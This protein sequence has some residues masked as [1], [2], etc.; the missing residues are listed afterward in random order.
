MMNQSILRHSKLVAMTCLIATL[1]G[2]AAA[3]TAVKKRNLEVETKMSD[4]IFLDPVAPEQQV[5]FVQLRNTS[6]KQDLKIK[7][8]IEQKLE[9]RGYTVT[10]NPKEAHYLLQANI[11]KAGKTDLRESQGLLASGYGGAISGAALGA[12]ASASM[13]SDASNMAGFGLLGA[14]VGFAADA[15]VEDVMFTIVTD[16]QISERAE[17]GVV[18]TE[19]N[20]AS[21]KQ[22]NS[23]AKQVSSTK[24]TDWHRY[25]TRI[26]STAN[27]VNLEFDEAIPELEN[28]LSQAISGMF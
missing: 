6:D 15:L 22:G 10:K 28:G 11:L 4:T 2:C 5:I 14:A 7:G 13:S 9:N 21:L 1:T 23:G 27:Q 26:M 12:L 24:K 17:D 25:Q 8:L 19:S 20:T 16:L 3:T 18:V